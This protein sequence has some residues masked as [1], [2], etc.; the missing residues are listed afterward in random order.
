MDVSTLAMVAVRENQG[1]PAEM[2]V[3]VKVLGKGR[4]DHRFRGP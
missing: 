3:G 2:G 4:N 1:I